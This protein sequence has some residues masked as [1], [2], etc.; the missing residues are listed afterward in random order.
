MKRV[1]ILT[2][3]SISLHNFP[4]GIA[5]YLACLKGLEVGFPI[6]I[7]IAAHNIPEG[8]AVASPIYHST[9]SKWEAFKWSLVS[10][11]C[12]PIA[13]FIFGTLLSNY[14]T[15]EM[16]QLLLAGVAGIMVLV[17]MKELLPVAFEYLS[18]EESMV[19]SAFGMMFISVSIYVLHAM[20]GHDH[21][22]HDH[23]HSHGHHG[24]HDHDHHHHHD[25]GHDHSHDHGHHH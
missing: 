23:S 6:A 22:S 5:V 15:D 19:S 2:A 10:G 17:S 14:I 7:A 9:G 25:H 12:E 21:G 4:E 24:I 8:M 11:M 18:P 20:G 16:V 3:L 1:G 13:A